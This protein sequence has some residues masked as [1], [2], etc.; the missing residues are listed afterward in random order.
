ML[1]RASATRADPASAGFRRAARNLAT[2]GASSSGMKIARALGASLVGT[3]AELV[4]VEARYEER[5]RGNTEILLTGL[6][7][8]VLRE[9]KGRLESALHANDIELGKGRLYLNL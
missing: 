9:A 2:A 1:A 3:R 7:D 4:T 6:P 8:P 5:D